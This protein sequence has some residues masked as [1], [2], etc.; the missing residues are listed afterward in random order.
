VSEQQISVL[1]AV[2]LEV[3]LVGRA[4]GDPYPPCLACGAMPRRVIRRQPGSTKLW[5]DDPSV[6]EF[7]GCGHVLTLGPEALTEFV[8]LYNAGHPLAETYLGLRK[9]RLLPW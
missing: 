2:R 4:I 9:W 3:H 8:E 1:E 5:P 6:W 7:E